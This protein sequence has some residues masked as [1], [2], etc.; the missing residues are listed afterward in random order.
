VVEFHPQVFGPCAP[1]CWG[2][3]RAGCTTLMATLPG[4]RPPR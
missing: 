3:H 2:V 4:R 1:H